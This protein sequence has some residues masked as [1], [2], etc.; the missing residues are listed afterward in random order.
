MSMTGHHLK[1]VLRIGSH[2]VCVPYMVLVRDRCC[3]VTL[4]LISFSHPRTDYDDFKIAMTSWSSHCNSI[5]K[6]IET[7]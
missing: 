7:I 4:Q 6:T 2:M 1:E 5:F 3:D